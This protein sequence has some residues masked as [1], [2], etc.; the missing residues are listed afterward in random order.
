MPDLDL[1]ELLTR[2]ARGTTLLF[3][4]FA[5]VAVIAMLAACG[6][7]IFAP[8]KRGELGAKVAVVL[9]GVALGVGGVASAIVMQRRGERTIDLAMNR[10]QDIVKLEIV[11]VKQRALST[12]GV[13]MTDT[14]GARLGSQVASEAEARQ[15]VAQL[16]AAG[17]KG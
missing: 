2:R 5:V 10:P 14:K 6:G 16:R 1:K 12:W 7:G 17:A 11:C 9:M 3:R 13:W 15:V 4:G 8:A